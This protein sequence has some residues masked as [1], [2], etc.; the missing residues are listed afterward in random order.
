MRLM[1]KIY[2]SKLYCFF[3]GA[4]QYLVFKVTC[5]LCSNS[6]YYLSEAGLALAIAL[7]LIP[8]HVACTFQVLKSQV[9]ATNHDAL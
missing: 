9:Y 2:F 5:L 3:P 4:P 7:R 8:T 1:L 6:C